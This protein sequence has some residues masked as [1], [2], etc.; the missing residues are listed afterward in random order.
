VKVELMHLNS[1]SS[2]YTAALQTN[3]FNPV[4]LSVVLFLS[5]L[6]GVQKVVDEMS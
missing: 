6:A 4:C 3:V 1:W 2:V 5:P